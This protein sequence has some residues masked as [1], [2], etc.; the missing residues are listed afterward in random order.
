[1]DEKELKKAL[2]RFIIAGK[3]W[4][5]FA[6]MLDLIHK[7]NHCIGHG[8]SLFVSSNETYLIKGLTISYTICEFE[9][10]PKQN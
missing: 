2:K 4:L 5:S 9:T 7:Q 3:S 8:E 1:M 6:F 10:N